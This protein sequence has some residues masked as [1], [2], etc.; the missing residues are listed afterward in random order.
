MGATVC[1]AVAADPE[2]ELV[3][4]VDPQG[5]GSI[6]E[7]LTIAAHPK[8]FADAG[9]EVVVDFTV[10][11]AARTTVP[12]LAMHG[13][14]AVVGTTGL[15][16]DDL[17]AFRSEFSGD[18]PNCVLAANFSIS[19]VL[20]MRFA[21]LAAPFFDT[22]EI[23]ELHHDT[24]TD[25]PSGTALAT[26]ERMAA[27][28]THWSPDPTTTEVIAGARGGAGPAGIHLHS[29][30]MRGMVAHQEVILGALGQTLILRQDSYD[31][32]SFMPGVLLACKRV[33]ERPGVTVGL[34]AIL[35]L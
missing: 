19:A 28:S 15:N 2:L 10:A 34:D 3:A 35:G 16:D 8:A 7:G 9:A 17:A 32:A 30:R 6:V 12:W 5:A 24:K 4:A 1:V 31:R 22:A 21:E 27:A 23:I 33:A 13:I 18:G 14:H 26:A 20:M 25:A 29:V 11:A